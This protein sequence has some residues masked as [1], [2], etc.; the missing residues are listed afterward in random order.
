MELFQLRFTA[1]ILF[2]TFVD[3]VPT[4]IC[5][6]K[7]FGYIYINCKQL[8]FILHSFRVQTVVVIKEFSMDNVTFDPADYPE[9]TSEPVMFEGPCELETT[10]Y[11]SEC[12]ITSTFQDY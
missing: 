6:G 3:K 7:S 9:F 10:E 5:S 2:S 11:V 12:L 8:L 4:T 1:F